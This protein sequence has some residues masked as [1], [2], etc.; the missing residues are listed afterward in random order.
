V[1]P[2]AGRSSWLA[3]LQAAIK[4]HLLRACK[5]KSFFCTA[6]ANRIVEI[7][8]SSDALKFI[9]GQAPILLGA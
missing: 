4:S 5:F 2:E 8:P 3:G 1:K 9:R 6:D 7:E